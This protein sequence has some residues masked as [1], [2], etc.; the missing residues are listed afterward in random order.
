MLISSLFVRTQI[1]EEKT[2]LGAI[3]LAFIFDL[4]S[5]MYIL[6]SFEIVNELA[7]ELGILG[8]ENY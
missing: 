1:G 4:I 2:R 5:I 3:L 7:F 8:L 6:F